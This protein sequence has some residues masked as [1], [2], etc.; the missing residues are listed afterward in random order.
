MRGDF[1]GDSGMVDRCIGQNSEMTSSPDFNDPAFV[2]PLLL[3]GQTAV[4]RCVIKKKPTNCSTETGY[5]ALGIDPLH[6]IAWVTEAK[7]RLA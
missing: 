6:E 5:K 4:K 7:V 2:C 1:R 3:T